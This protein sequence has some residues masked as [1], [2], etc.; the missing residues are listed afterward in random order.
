MRRVCLVLAIVP[1]L[2][3][4]CISV[5]G[6]QPNML[7]T[8]QEIALGDKF[9]KEVEAEKKVLDDPVIQDYVNTIGNH[10]A[11]FSPRKDIQYQFTVI[12]DPEEVNAFALP[13][14]HLYFY[15][16]LMKLCENEAQLAAVMAHEMAHVAEHHHGE[17]L[18]RR[19]GLEFLASMI[20]GEE[21]SEFANLAAQLLGSGLLMNYSRQNEREAD[22][23][24]MRMLY[25]GGYDPDGMVAFMNS[26][27][28]YERSKGGGHP[29][30][31]FSSHPPTQERMSYLNVLAQQYP[32]GYDVVNADVYRAKVLERLG[33]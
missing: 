31:I 18:T 16:G 28:E 14:G 21:P 20:L 3:D 29:L 2:S 33:G 27:L 30:P 23:L 5:E 26:M 8:Q 9:A 24:G 4:G 7:T 19:Y 10:L 1:L 22:Q 6:V 25:Q 13:G 32:P 12:D 15:T 11:R 17:N